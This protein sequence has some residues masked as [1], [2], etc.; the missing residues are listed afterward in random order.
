MKGDMYIAWSADSAIR[1][2]A[3]CG[4]AVTAL[5]KCALESKKVDAVLAVKARNGNR[6]DGIPVLVTDPEEVI[7]T[8]GSLP[9]ASPNIARFLKEY[10]DGAANLKIAVVCKPCDARAIIELVKRAQ[11]NLDNLILI[12]LNCT[13]TL[14]SAKAQV[15]IRAEFDVTPDDVVGEDIEDGKLTIMLKDGTE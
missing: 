2:R 12:G 9:C 6:Y 1:G 15:M 14:P 5:L 13:S 4:G 10:L 7:E 8:S 3:E 11:I